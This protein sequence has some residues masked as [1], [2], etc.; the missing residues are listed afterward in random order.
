MVLLSVVFFFIAKY[1]VNNLSDFKKYNISSI[2]FL[3]LFVSLPFLWFKLCITSLSY[4]LVMAKIA[5]SIKLNENLKIWS[6]SYLGL[7]IPGKIGVL[8]FRI[9]DYNKYGISS[10]K[11]SYG[12]FVEIILS[13]LSSCFIVLFCG[14]LVKMDLVIGYLPWLVALFIILIVL[15]HPRLIHFYARLYF[16]YIRKTDN[17]YTAP[18][19]YLFYIKIILLHILKW[20]FVGIG[21]FI[22]INSVT[23]L[24]WSYLPFVTGLYAA[25]T[26][27]GI[28][29]FFAPS[30]IGVVEGVMIIG[31]KT[32]LSSSLAGAISIL[33][34]I[35]KVIGE[36]SFIFLLNLSLQRTLRIKMFEKNEIPDISSK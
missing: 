5:P 34:R 7:Y 21:V 28:I 13:L 2:S 22:L 3:G 32:I 24:S 18:F 11:V 4:H 17:Y 12:F 29:A 14:L 8:A 20:C 6:K 9:L 16:K 31:L 36:L 1:F 25:A 35:W 26:I 10:M 19:S 27:I 30:G 15:V 23:D 33:I